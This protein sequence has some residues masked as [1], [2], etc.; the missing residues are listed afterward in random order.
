[1]AYRYLLSTNDI[2][3]DVDGDVDVNCDGEGESDSGEYSDQD[4]VEDF[5]GEAG[6][7]V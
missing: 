6:D 1:M 5:H 7:I 4:L 2:Y 3:N